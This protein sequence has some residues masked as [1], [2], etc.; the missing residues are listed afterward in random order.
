MKRRLCVLLCMLLMSTILVATLGA[1]LKI[2]VFS[3]AGLFV[4]RSVMEVPFAAYADSAARFVL[5]KFQKQKEQ[6][7]EFSL[8]CSL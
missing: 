5:Q 2:E 3:P 1:Y 8:I 7:A 6:Q 4:D